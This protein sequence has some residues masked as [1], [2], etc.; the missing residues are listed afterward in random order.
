MQKQNCS[1]IRSELESCQI[2]LDDKSITAERLHCEVKKLNELLHKER[3]RATQLQ[4]DLQLMN[5]QRTNVECEFENFLGDSTS[6]KRILVSSLVGLRRLR[7]Q[8]ALS[9][10]A[11]GYKHDTTSRH[12]GPS[13][14]HLKKLFDE[15]SHVEEQARGKHARSLRNIKSRIQKTKRE[16]LD[17]E[18]LTHD[19]KDALLRQIIGNLNLLYEVPQ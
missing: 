15:V 4:N 8:R 9:S 14:L 10:F 19:E 11:D 2:E 7:E 1:Q 16:Y 12:V 3:S 17:Y 13:T 5:L 6:I 18:D